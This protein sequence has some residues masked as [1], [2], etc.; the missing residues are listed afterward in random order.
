MEPGCRQEQ[1]EHWQWSHLL[2]LKA[3]CGLPALCM[4]PHTFADAPQPGHPAPVGS[5]MS[6]AGAAYGWGCGPQQTICPFSVFRLRP[7]PFNALRTKLSGSLRSR[8][9]ASLQPSDLVLSGLSVLVSRRPRSQSLYI[10]AL[11]IGT[12]VPQT[13]PWNRCL[14]IFALPTYPTRTK[15]STQNMAARIQKRRYLNQVHLISVSSSKA[16]PSSRGS[17]PDSAI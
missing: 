11:S 17:C 2:H 13:H 5:P 7:T 15:S 3:L 14:V 9:L 8:L 12:L 6:H 10:L 16:H 4:Y 1:T